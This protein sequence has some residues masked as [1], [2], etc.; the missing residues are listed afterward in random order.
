M[1]PKVSNQGGR[2]EAAWWRWCPGWAARWRWWGWRTMALREGL[3]CGRGGIQGL[4]QSSWR[5]SRWGR[6]CPG[7]AKES[8]GGVP[9]GW[10]VQGRVWGRSGRWVGRQATAPLPAPRRRR[11]G[12]EAVKTP[13]AGPQPAERAAVSKRRPAGPGHA[14]GG[15]SGRS[16]QGRAG[17]R[18]PSRDP[19]PRP[20]RGQRAAAP[21]PPRPAPAARRSAPRAPSGA[22]AAAAAAAGAAAGNRPAPGRRSK[23][24]PG[25]AL[26]WARFPRRSWRGRG[27]R[28]WPGAAASAR[29]TAAWTSAT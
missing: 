2:G 10:A 23:P 9:G 19:A 6:D 8:G 3:V 15:C 5:G 17:S 18:E 28:C 26:S 14:G 11:A 21:P 27:A 29:G 13:S 1:S 16:G 7:T 25:G 20:E 12:T 24:G 4:S 22:G